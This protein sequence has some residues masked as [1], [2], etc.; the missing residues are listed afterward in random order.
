MHSGEKVFA[1]TS[2]GY[3]FS[4]VRITDGHL[5]CIQVTVNKHSSQA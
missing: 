2:Q 4:G 5:I 1:G 3:C